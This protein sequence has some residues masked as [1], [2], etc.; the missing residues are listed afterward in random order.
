MDG[1][2]VQ[3]TYW[4]FGEPNDHGGHEDCVET[5]WGMSG[6]WN[7]RKCDVLRPFLCQ[8]PAKGGRN[9][10]GVD[11]GLGCTNEQGVA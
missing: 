10:R 6:N 3:K 1:T 11:G 5:N 9:R 2:P 7:D 4:G 8:K